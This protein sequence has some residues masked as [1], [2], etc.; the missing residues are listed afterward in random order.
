M[1][2]EEE[3]YCLLDDPELFE[4]GDDS[5]WQA[6][7]S[8]LP[9]LAVPGADRRFTD[10]H[11]QWAR[12]WAT[13]G[14]KIEEVED[15]DY[16][17]AIMLQAETGSPWLIVLDEEAFKSGEVG[18]ILRDKKGNPVKETTFCHPEEVNAFY[19]SVEVRGMLPESGYWEHGAVG[20]KYRAR[21]KI[22]RKLLP[23]VKG[24]S[25]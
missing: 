16:E 5:G 13:D 20:R 25:D 7:Y 14:K 6:V 10:D 2:P 19:I 18:L 9:E 17:N 24:A 12:S 4:F 22:M 8:V 15:E 21:G 23:I 1:E 11:V 3:W